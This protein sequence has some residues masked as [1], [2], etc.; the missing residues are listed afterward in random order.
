MT[1]LVV[2]S[3]ALR[4]SRASRRLCDAQGGL[5]FG[6]RVSTLR[7]LVPGLLARAGDPRG[8]LTPLAERLLA[9]SSASEA[10]L[11]G[12]MP[13]A[14]G[15]ARAAA[16]VIGELRCG[17]VA[18]ADA[19]AAADGAMG[20]PAERLR[21]ISAA[22]QAYERRLD[23]MRALDGAA[24]LRA[25]AEAARRGG[26][27]EETADLG[28]LVVE[29][30]LAPSPAALDLVGTL[31][32]RARRVLA[33][34]PYLPADPA[35]SAPAEPWV[36]RFES[37][38]ELAARREVALEFPGGSPA[39]AVARALGVEAGPGASDGRVAALPA[40]GDEEQAE[41]AA[42]FAADLL[43]GG[44][45]PEEVAVV[46]PRRL[47]ERLA[48][49]CDRL[50]VPLA[51]A[52]ESPLL[53]SAPMRDVRAALAAAE[54]LDRSSAERLLGSPYLRF[55]GEAPEGLARLLD[56]AGALEAR[57]A[58]EERLRERARGLTAPLLSA[59]RERGELLRAAELLGRVKSALA[60]LRAPAA[61]REWASRL[62]AFLDRAGARRRAARGEADLA[63]RDLAALSLLEDV[64]DD[65]CVA[66]ALL[67]RAGEP[68]D[69]TEWLGLLD[70]AAG[71]ASVPA[72]PRV[73]AGALE[74]W[75]PEEAPGLQARAVLVLG[76]ERGAWPM[77]PRPDP[78]LGD[79]ARF[80]L[81]RHLR[82]P[83]LPGAAARH[84]EAE[85][86]GLSA[87]CAGSE[88]LGVA[89]T[90]GPE[91]EGPAPLAAEVLARGAAQELASACDPP[92]HRARSES[93]AL[94]AGARLRCAAASEV[95]EAAAALPP[96]W[97]FPPGHDLAARARSAAERGA[98]ERE[99]RRSALEGLPR[100]GCGSIP[101]DLLG[102]WEKALP[103]EWSATQLEAH[104]RCPYR[105]FLQ[106]AGVPDLE[107]ADL[108]MSPRD[109]G[110][111]LHAALEAWL[112]ARRDRG[113]WP[114]DGS[115]GDRAELRRIASQVF[116]GFESEGRVGDRGAWM[117]R[118]ASLL[119][120]LERWLEGEAS[121]WDGL[122]PALLEYEFGGSSGRPP[123][124][125]PTSEGAILLRGRIDRVDADGRRLLVLDYK[126]SRGERAHRERL[127]PS[128]LGRT[129][130]QPALYVL[131]AA[132]ELPGR[133]DF[134][135]SYGLL[136]S[137]ERV[138][139]WRTGPADPFLS[140]EPREA[141]KAG[142]GS[143]RTF[144]DSVVASVSRIRSGVL[145]IASRDCSGCPFGAVCRFPR[146]GDGA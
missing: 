121:D 140:L 3:T 122:T 134:A 142:E 123:V 132:R 15:G 63:R 80:A 28:L 105:F 7:A 29:G 86:L 69:R 137:T 95:G 4:Q 65:L 127:D 92:F 17:E 30:F 131:A 59:R 129:S 98:R 111:L 102:A 55:G 139:P 143:G 106:V 133:S 53:A 88:V 22:L 91:G 16:E 18:A 78:L 35:R 145:P 44:Y 82:R 71:S 135:A 90:R 23:E 19:R 89:W 32:Q 109:E 141:R 99:G 103:P 119:R 97:P 118:R 87:L 31:A 120:R 57:G 126:N 14:S 11:I 124:A 101:Q 68:L 108:D 40:A 77:A 10:G 84:A 72:A 64:L 33:R 9:C 47:W 41:G 45:A 25:A 112:R 49:S 104:A 6:P 114:P 66:L 73:V 62:R 113:D 48:V 26:T 5:L 46:A 70:L 39:S 74:L 20:R 125:I 146:P 52:V 51:A 50:A 38:H 67:G 136:R 37:L 58:P 130:F 2:V 1:D 21:A 100:G 83:A 34:I 79:A 54:V 43:E 8:L 110:R 12:R 42:R 96:S 94:R 117:A 115:E 138:A 61:P 81:N 76:A 13:P 24:A 60:P 75:P 36:R 116:A 56:R 85:Y 128:E 144:A 107:P 27:S 93:E